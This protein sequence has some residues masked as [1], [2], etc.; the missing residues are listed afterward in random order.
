MAILRRR[1]IEIANA[2]V[3]VPKVVVTEQEKLERKAMI[4]L[5]K[6]Y[7]CSNMMEEMLRMNARAQLMLY[8]S[9]NYGQLAKKDDSG[10]ILITK[11]NLDAIPNEIV[12]E[13]DFNSKNVMWDA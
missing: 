10:N 12:S 13:S 6:C 2:N 7:E 9:P 4:L 5:R 1:E 3:E 8:T 11:E